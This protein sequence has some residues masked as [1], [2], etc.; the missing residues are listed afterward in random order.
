MPVKLSSKDIAA[1]EEAINKKGRTEANVK[2]E[3]GKIVVVEV[4]KKKIN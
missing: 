1:I 4:T 3:D 2:K